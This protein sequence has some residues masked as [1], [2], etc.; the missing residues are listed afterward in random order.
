MT[1]TRSKPPGAENPALR[2]LDRLTTAEAA[3][4]LGLHDK[5]LDYKRRQ[6]YLQEAEGSTGRRKFYRRV[7]LD[8]E[9][10]RTQGHDKPGRKPGRSPAPP[11]SPESVALERLI[12]RYA[13]NNKGFR[14]AFRKGYAAAVSGQPDSANPY[15]AERGRLTGHFNAWMAGY[16]AFKDTSHEK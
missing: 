9:W 14:G 5:A 1:Q 2:N 6:G 16:T 15:P 11:P 8:K 3:A 12:D 7:D 10:E 4:Y 13:P